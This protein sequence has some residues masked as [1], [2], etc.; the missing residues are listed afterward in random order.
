MRPPT[1]TMAIRASTPMRPQ[2]ARISGTA[3]VPNVAPIL[4]QAAAK[5]LADAR[6]PVGNSTGAKVKVVAFGPAFM[7]KLNSTKPPM[8]K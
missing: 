1:L 2:A 4:A 8:I 3:K 6:I 7:A 5:P